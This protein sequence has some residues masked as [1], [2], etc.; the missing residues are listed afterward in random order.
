M[1]KNITTGYQN[2]VA[3]EFQGEVSKADFDSVIMPAVNDLVENY[4][5]LNLVYY[6]NTEL[7]NFDVGAWWQDAML[8]LKNITKWHKAAIVTENSAVQKFTEL[9]G[10]IMPGSFKA[11]DKEQLQ[12]AIDWAAN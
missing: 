2:L 5:E 10:I 12:E 6:I 8:G 11:F 4:D 3:F 9:F 7:K 1:I